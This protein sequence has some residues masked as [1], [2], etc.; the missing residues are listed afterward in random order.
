MAVREGALIARGA[1]VLFMDAYGATRVSDMAALEEALAAIGTPAFGRRHING[2][3]GG[4]ARVVGQGKKNSKR[5]QDWSWSFV[6]PLFLSP[7]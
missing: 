3:P 4:W 1:A 6:W 7:S 5:F 2:P